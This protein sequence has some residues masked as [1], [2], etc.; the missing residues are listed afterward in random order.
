MQSLKVLF[1]RKILIPFFLFSSIFSLLYAPASNQRADLEA[2]NGE[3]TNTGQANNATDSSAISSNGEEELE[4]NREEKY[5][6]RFG[7]LLPNLKKMEKDGVIASYRF[8]HFLAKILSLEKKIKGGFYTFTKSSNTLKVLMRLS[9]GTEDVYS[10]TIYEG[11]DLYDIDELLLE[12]KIINQ[13]YAFLDYANHPKTIA[14][15]LKK[16]GMIFSEKQ[17]MPK[18]LEGFLYPNT[19]NVRASKA[20]EELISLAANQFYAQITS[21]FKQNNVAEKHWYSFLIIA[22]LIEKETSLESERG[23]VSSVIFNRLEKKMKLRFD[24]TIIYALKFLKLYHANLRDGYIDIKKRH[25]TLPSSYN[26]Y[27][28]KGLPP[29]PIANPTLSSVKAAVFPTPSPYLFFVA[30]AKGGKN[31]LGHDFSVTYEEHLKKIN[32]YLKR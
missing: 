6:Y 28:R 3:I 19:Y 1:N 4:K 17:A 7:P 16:T 30:R 32:R 24:P 18:T 9:K 5:Q 11:Y 14:A 8:A 29:T 31:Q 21:F 10:I 12:K 27:Y 13:R 2:T 15:V 22:S 25:F 23:L 20:K 26:T